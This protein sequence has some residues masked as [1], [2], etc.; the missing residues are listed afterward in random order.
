MEGR[1]EGRGGREGK[2]KEGSM[3]CT[4]GA[5]G[6]VQSISHDCELLIEW[7][8]R[9]CGTHPGNGETPQINP[10]CACEHVMYT[11]LTYLVDYV[12]FLLL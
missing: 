10:R 8:E 2:D 6:E 5:L 9:G 12:V 7:K 3:G 4:A 11:T 1:R